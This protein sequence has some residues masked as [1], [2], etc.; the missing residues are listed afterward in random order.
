[1]AIDFM[2]M[3]LSRYLSGDF[4]TPTM[5]FAWQQGVAYSLFGPGSRRDI[6]KDTPFGGVDA[7]TNRARFVPM[8]LDDLK[9][10]PS[11]LG[12]NLWDEA[13]NADPIFHR[14]EPKSYVSLLEEAKTRETRPSLLG[15]MKRKTP[16]PAH[17]AAMVFLPDPFDVPFDMPVVFERL[18]GSAPVALRELEGGGWAD[19]ASSARDTLMAAL[20][21]AIR[22][23][24]PMIV[25]V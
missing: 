1:M 12:A 11:A 3:P 15:L 22:L 5:T 24:L 9:K 21:D 4:V 7:P 19:A 16:G 23:R 17:I 6:P 10:L 8:L 25:D 13:S 2:I 14:V 20:R 18:A